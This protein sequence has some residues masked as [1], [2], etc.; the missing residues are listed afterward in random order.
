MKLAIILPAFNEA[1]I[2][3]SVLDAVPTSILGIDRVMTLVIDDGSTDN[4][5]EVAEQHGAMVVRH[6]MNRGVG[7]ATK[8]GI[9]QAKKLR[10]DI[11]VTI[12]SD[13]QHNPADLPA[14]IAPILAGE[15]DVV[16]G[17]RLVNASGMPLLKIFGNKLMNSIT[18]LY[19]GAATTDSQS[20]FR[21]YNQ[22]AL[23]RMR[24]SS[25]GYEI[26]SEIL[27][28]IRRAHLRLVEV[29]VDTIYTA[30]SRKKGQSITNGLNI[31]IRLTV[32]A[33]TR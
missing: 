13:G 5:A 6:R 21:A 28:A 20:G 12:D 15:S 4:T 22:A 26:C 32:R 17:T 1:S 24:L 7:V 8:T 29:P 25:S 31:I 2:I 14:V 16:I 33:I 3:G 23:Q 9:Q 19:G 11:A 30:Y 10:A 18:R 27:G